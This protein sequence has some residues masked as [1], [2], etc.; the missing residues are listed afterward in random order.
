MGEL[1]ELSARPGERHQPAVI[2]FERK[3]LGL[4][5]LT[6]QILRHSAHIARNGHS[7]VI[8]DDQQVF[9]ALPGVGQALIGQS[10]GERA[11]TDEGH[12]MIVLPQH[13]PGMGHAQ[14]HGH[15]IGS[16][17]GDKGVGNALPRLGE[18]GNTAKLAHSV[19]HIRPSG[20][21]FVD[22][23]LVSHIKDQPIPGQVK[24]PVQRHRQLHRAQIG[25]Q[26]PTRSGDTAEQIL[27]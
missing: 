16:V 8:E 22:V 13:S 27:P 7:V 10:A 1:I 15:G 18:P 4:E 9:L 5:P 17:P 19:H 2:S 20:E 6:G 25:G 11:V 24:Y 21:H 23:A 3:I 26:M 12:H 14:R